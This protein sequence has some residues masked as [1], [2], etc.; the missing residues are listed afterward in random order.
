[1]SLQ[2]RSV[3]IRT[4][5]QVIYRDTIMGK[6]PKGAVYFPPMVAIKTDFELPKEMGAVCVNGQWFRPA[7]GEEF[8][9]KWR[10]L[11]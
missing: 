9:V 11:E 5:M 3:E 8:A 4:P 2:I 1:M 7:D 10:E 6:E